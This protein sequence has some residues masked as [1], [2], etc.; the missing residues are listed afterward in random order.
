V[1]VLTIL[2]KEGATQAQEDEAQWIIEALD[3]AYPEHPW[4]VR[5]YDGGFFIQHMNLPS[6]WGMNCKGTYAS[7]SLLKRDVILK[8]GEFLERAGLRRGKWDWEEDIKRVEGVA[9]EV[10]TT[11]RSI[12]LPKINFDAVIATAEREMRDEVR[13]QAMELAKKMTA[14][15]THAG[16][17]RRESY[18]FMDTNWRRIGITASRPFAGS[19]PPALST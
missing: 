18:I 12:E 10:A 6:N 2:H 4:K 15:E 11:A 1:Q 19:T 8:A 7:A 13:P 17:F 9:G 16:G 3:A 14:L 5:V